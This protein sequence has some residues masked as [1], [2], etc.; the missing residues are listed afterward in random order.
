MEEIRT[1]GL[2]LS[3]NAIHA[4]KKEYSI[5]KAMAL[6]PEIVCKMTGRRIQFMLV[7]YRLG[8][9]LNEMYYQ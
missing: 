6:K 9:L 1:K 8:A 7:R 3:T 5:T 4:L 2:T